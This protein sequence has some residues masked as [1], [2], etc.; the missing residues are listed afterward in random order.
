[1]KKSQVQIGETVAVLLVFFILVLMGFSF[2]TKVIKGTIRDE[3][4]EARQLKAVEI[5]QRVS[6][7]PE[8]KCRGENVDNCID[9]L[10]LEAASEIMRQN[11]IFYFDILEFATISIKEIYPEEESWLLYDR[12][13]NDVNNISTRVPIALK[14]PRVKKYKFGVMQVN[15]FLR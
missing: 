14:D 6:F 4:E 12:T 10:K 2:Y 5:A 11:E 8:L 3:M 13:L 1:M 9:I 7:L 15:T